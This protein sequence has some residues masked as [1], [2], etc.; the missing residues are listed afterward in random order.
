MTIQSCDDNTIV[1]IH[2]YIYIYRYI[3]LHI[4]NARLS[5]IYI[6]MVGECN[7]MDIN[8]Y[9]DAVSAMFIYDHYIMA[10]YIHV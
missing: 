6:Y 8:A 2:I 7:I 3:Y 4:F 10:Y 9:D 5:Y 1:N